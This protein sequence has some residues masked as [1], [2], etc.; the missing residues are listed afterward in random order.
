MLRAKS[1]LDF[2]KIDDRGSDSM[3]QIMSC[4]TIITFAI[5]TN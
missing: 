2:L 1:I 5:L 4:H 3:R